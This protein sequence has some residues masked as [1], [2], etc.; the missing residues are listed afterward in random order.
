MVK[1]YVSKVFSEKCTIYIYI[2]IYLFI[3]DNYQGWGDE[4]E[5]EMNGKV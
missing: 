1:L 5:Y 4:G 2:Y 3:I